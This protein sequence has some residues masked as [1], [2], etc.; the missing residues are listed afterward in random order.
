MRFTARWFGEIYGIPGLRRARRRALRYHGAEMPKY[1]LLVLVFVGLALAASAA[2]AAATAPTSGDI[3]LIA[4]KGALHRYGARYPKRA[5]HT[6]YYVEVNGKGQVSK[7]RRWS[8]SRD[9]RFDALTYGNVVQLYVRRNDGHIVAGVYKIG[10]DYNPKTQVVLRSVKLI[11]PGGID[12]T[13]LGLV[14]VFKEINRQNA[15]K[16]KA[17]LEKIRL[18][19]SPSSSPKPE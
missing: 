2:A 10:Y 4:P 14:D 13:A 6:R 1:G 12:D 15:A 5:Q 7:V 3:P 17:T 9:P 8:R 18:A 16:A 19:P 11:H